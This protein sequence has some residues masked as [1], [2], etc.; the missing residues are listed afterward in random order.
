MQNYDFTLYSHQFITMILF[1]PYCRD[2]WSDVF[3]PKGQ[4]NT[5]SKAMDAWDLRNSFGS[6]KSL[7]NKNNEVISFVF[8]KN[9]NY[10]LLASQF[11]YIL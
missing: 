1:P 9:S 4:Y 11:Y 3:S 10:L 2:I 8:F 7:H 6:K 5:T